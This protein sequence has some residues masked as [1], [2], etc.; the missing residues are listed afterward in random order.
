MGKEDVVLD[1]AAPAPVDRANATQSEAFDW[2]TPVRFDPTLL[3]KLIRGHETLQTR[4]TALPP[5]FKSNRAEACREAHDCA[6]QLHELRRAEALWL[7]PVLSRGLGADP[8]VWRQLVKLRF[9]MNGCARHLLRSLEDLA[10][11][12]SDATDIKPATGAALKALAEYR[13]RNETELYALY[14]LMDPRAALPVNAP[15]LQRK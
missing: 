3:K 2:R 7:Y 12:A 5:V 6:A 11:A 13:Q 8:P 10:R 1:R 15:R 4:L 9:V 14:E